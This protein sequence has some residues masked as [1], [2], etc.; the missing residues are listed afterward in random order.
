M[1]KRLFPCFIQLKKK[2]KTIP[3]S[4]ND[5]LCMKNRTIKQNLMSAVSAVEFRTKRFKSDVN[6]LPLLPQYMLAIVGNEIPAAKLLNETEL[7]RNNIIVVKFIPV[8]ITK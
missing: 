7:I 3:I 4:D 8:E 2:K 5:K 1:T 6:I